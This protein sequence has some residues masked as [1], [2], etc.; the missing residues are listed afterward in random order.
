M[1]LK[2]EPYGTQNNEAQYNRSQHNSIQDNSTQSNDSQHNVSLSVAFSYCY[3]ECR[4]AK[5]RYAECN[6]AE[7]R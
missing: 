2:K 1:C 4:S 6:Y 3:A 5:L 7:G